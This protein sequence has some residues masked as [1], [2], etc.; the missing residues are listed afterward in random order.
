VVWNPWIEKAARLADLPDDAYHH[1]VCVEAAN[2]GPSAVT[3][4][5]GTSHLIGT[6]I[7]VG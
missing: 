5:P 6:R 1:F 3:I 4:K 7:S 2:T